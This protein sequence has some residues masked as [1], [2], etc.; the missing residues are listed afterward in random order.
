MFSSTAEKTSYFAGSQTRHR[1]PR[2]TG[3][4]GRNQQPPVAGVTSDHTRG[5]LKQQR[6]LLSRLWRPDIRNQHGADARLES[7]RR[8]GCT[9]DK[10]TDKNQPLPLPA[11]GDPRVLRLWPH[12]C[13]L[14]LC[15]HVAPSSSVCNPLCTSSYRHMAT[16]TAHPDN[17]GSSPHLKIPNVVM[18]ARSL[19]RK[20]IFTGS[21][22]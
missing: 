3:Q 8:Q 16:V 11:S 18:F 20:V 13:S 17:P 19:P 22:A 6:S 14:C 12:H 10:P 5:G 7:G 4:G 2:A 1:T 9:S 21:R 15:G